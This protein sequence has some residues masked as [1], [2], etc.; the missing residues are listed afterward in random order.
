MGMPSDNQ[1]G[2]YYPSCERIH[3]PYKATQSGTPRDT[4]H[5]KDL[6]KS[7]YKNTPHGEDLTKRTSRGKP[8]GDNRTEATLRRQPYE[9]N[10][11]ETTTRRRPHKVDLTE[12]TYKSNPTDGTSREEPHEHKTHKNNRVN[13]M[14]KNITKTSKN[15]TPRSSLYETSQ[16][17]T[18][19]NR[20]AGNAT[21][22]CTITH[23]HTNNRRK[24]VNENTMY[25]PR[26]SGHQLETC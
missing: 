23:P 15:E 20:H 7:R 6:T 21:L 24:H 4:P 1:R 19:Q 26:V 25:P 10:I 22:H 11:T 14:W 8:Y 17:N 13:T 18:L 2:T 5:E 9:G 16:K 12:S 3:I